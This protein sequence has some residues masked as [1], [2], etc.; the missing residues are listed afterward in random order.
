MQE[1]RAY[2]NTAIGFTAASLQAG[3]G[4]LYASSHAERFAPRDLGPMEQFE[5]RNGELLVRE[6]RDDGIVLMLT[7]KRL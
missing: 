1:P 6:A 4:S 3:E 2:S 5:V 7:I